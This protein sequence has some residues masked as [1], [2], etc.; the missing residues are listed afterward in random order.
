MTKNSSDLSIFP[1]WDVIDRLLDIDETDLTG[2][3][4][5][6]LRQAIA[7]AKEEGR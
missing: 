1:P 6:A 7:R 5:T 3:D 2:G 4:I